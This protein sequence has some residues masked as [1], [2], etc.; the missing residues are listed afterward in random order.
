MGAA[1]FSAV[2][3]ILLATGIYALTG[4]TAVDPWL[5]LAESSEGAV[6]ELIFRGAI[7]RLLSSVFGIWGALGL[8]SGLFGALHVSKPGA[9]LMAV[10]GIILAERSRPRRAWVP[11]LIKTGAVRPRARG[12]GTE[13]RPGRNPGPSSL[14]LWISLIVHTPHTT[15][16]TAG[17]TQCRA[18]LLRPFG[19]HGFRGDQQPG[20]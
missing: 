20:N 14:R 13:K 12:C 18:F 7:F 15:H 16:T 17:H 9:D 2:M 19:D 10:L 4:P 11:H 8:S 6:E 5:P 3:A 1:L